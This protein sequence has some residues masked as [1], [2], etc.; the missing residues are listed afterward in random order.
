M[1]H[2]YHLN[3]PIVHQTKVDRQKNQQ[4]IPDFAYLM[5]KFVNYGFVEVVQGYNHKVTRHVVGF[6]EIKH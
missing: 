2:R 3:I 4:M 6:I 1:K 5:N